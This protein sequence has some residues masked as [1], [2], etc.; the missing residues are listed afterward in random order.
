MGLH[1]WKVRMSAWSSPLA[2]FAFRVE[3]RVLVES[4][5]THEAARIVLPGGS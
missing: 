1:P 4:V 5:P 2:A 3:V